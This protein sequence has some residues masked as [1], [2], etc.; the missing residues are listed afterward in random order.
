MGGNEA[1]AYILVI[2]ALLQ[3]YTLMISWEE[4]TPYGMKKHSIFWRQ[5]FIISAHLSG[6]LAE[7][8]MLPYDLNVIHH[9]QKKKSKKSI[10]FHIHLDDTAAE[11]FWTSYFAWG[12][13]CRSI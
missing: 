7:V 2:V 8:C 10:E 13:S 4:K 5:K 11:I 9:L 3:P 1:H 6:V 12:F